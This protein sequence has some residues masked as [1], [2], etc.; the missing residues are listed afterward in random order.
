MNEVNELAPLRTVSERSELSVILTLTLVL[1]LTLILMNVEAS[2][3]RL[4]VH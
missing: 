1:T 3:A 2:A 4:D